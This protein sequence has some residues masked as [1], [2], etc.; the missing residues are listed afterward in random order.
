MPVRLY[1]NSGGSPEPAPLVEFN[2]CHSPDD[3]KFCSGGAIRAFASVKGTAALGAL[4]H[5]E[6]F[7]TGRD[8]ETMAALRSNGRVFEGIGLLIGESD[9]VKVGEDNAH[10][11]INAQGEKLTLLHTH[12]SS[13]SPSFQD[14]RFAEKVNRLSNERFR[15]LRIANMAVL[16]K[17]G[18]LH[19]IRMLDVPDEYT[20]IRMQGAYRR[21]HEEARLRAAREVEG[22]Y[23]G[24]YP[25]EVRIDGGRIFRRYDGRPLD[26][27]QLMGFLE[28]RGH[29]NQFL[30]V[31]N[32]RFAKHSPAIWREI[33]TEFPDYISYEYTPPPKGRH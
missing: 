33:Q 13:S 20:S 27:T 32:E 7:G 21:H 18:A 19:E 3:G 1:P 23:A 14:F 11:M 5:H 4:L 30:Q 12:P 25:E 2:A 9:E 8:I 16:G 15:E 26:E 6:S 10:L 22:W 31:F 29:R 28:H 17:D 24:T